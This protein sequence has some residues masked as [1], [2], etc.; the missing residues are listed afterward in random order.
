TTGTKNSR[1]LAWSPD[2]R[3]SSSTGNWRQSPTLTTT[4][5]VGL[6]SALALGSLQRTLPASHTMLFGA[7]GTRTSPLGAT[8]GG[9]TSFGLPGISTAILATV[10]STAGSV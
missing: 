5:R 9:S 10:I 6:S 1:T 7:L 2:P 8:C 3:G 4:S